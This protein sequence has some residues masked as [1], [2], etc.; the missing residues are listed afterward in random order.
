MKYLIFLI[1]IVY[2]YSEDEKII[3]EIKKD[4][5]SD[6]ETYDVFFSTS[7][8]S[9]LTSNS[10]IVMNKNTIV[11]EYNINDGIENV[12]N[13][14]SA[15][16]E[17]EGGYLVACTSKYLIAYYKI[18]TTG[19]HLIKG[20]ENNFEYQY[21]CSVSFIENYA[22]V[23]MIKSINAESASA[24]FFPELYIYTINTVLEEFTYSSGYNINN[25][26]NFTFRCDEC[27]YYMKCFGSDE[28]NITCLFTNSSYI[29]YFSYPVDNTATTLNLDN[30]IF[31]SQNNI[32]ELKVTSSGKGKYMV[33][34]ID[35]TNEELP[36]NHFPITIDKMFEE[37]YVNPSYE[38]LPLNLK[39]YSGYVVS[40]TEYYCIYNDKYYMNLEKILIENGQRTVYTSFDFVY[41]NEEDIETFTS[42][43]D[44]NI[45]II[46]S[47]E[48]RG[49]NLIRF[50][51]LGDIKCTPDT[52]YGITEG[53]NYYNI[54]PKL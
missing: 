26:A 22:V 3:T 7:T 12:A 27:L 29:Y 10:I 44:N 46:E 23:S 31:L 25:A 51:Y 33:S 8:Y 45:Y 30:N 20:F 42:F 17:I 47:S 2:I 18:N 15:L 5:I 34:Y 14:F 28:M 53:D 24:I 36:H 52:I 11:H 19:I 16:M 21:K 6:S 39:S 13:K 37:K 40:Q 35:N 48:E 4:S 49:T 9:L 1:F 41:E 32:Y 43:Y 50:K 38:G 54:V